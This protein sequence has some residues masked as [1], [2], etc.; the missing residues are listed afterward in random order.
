MASEADFKKVMEGM[1]KAT[2]E[3]QKESMKEWEEWMKGADV[4][5]GGAPLGK[6]LRV[7][8]SEVS[9]TRNG[10]GGYSIIE[11]DSQEDAAKKMQTNPHFNMIPGGWIEVM[12]IMPM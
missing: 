10:I 4:V 5:D 6:T 1:G 9:D 3:E 8:P 12:E 2:P 11:A 7:T